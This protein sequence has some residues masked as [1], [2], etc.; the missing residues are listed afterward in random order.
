MSTVFFHNIP[1]F[2]SVF[3]TDCDLHYCSAYCK[4]ISTIQLHTSAQGM[5]C[6]LLSL[7]LQLDGGLAIFTAEGAGYGL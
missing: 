1:E 7:I 2:H 6:I 3:T 4:N 5:S